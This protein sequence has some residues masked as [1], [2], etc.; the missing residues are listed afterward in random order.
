MPAPWGE[1]GGDGGPAIPRGAGPSLP[2]LEPGHEP[3]GGRD[4]Y[5]AARNVVVSA[6]P[7]ASV[8]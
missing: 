7:S 3:L 6:G 4:R 2:A 8:W 5:P 1:G